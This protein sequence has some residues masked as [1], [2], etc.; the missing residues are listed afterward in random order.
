MPR[1]QPARVPRSGSNRSRDRHTLDEGL[2]GDVGREVAIAD[3]PRGV[4]EDQ[5]AACL[6]CQPESGGIPGGPGVAGLT[7][8]V[9]LG[10]HAGTVPAGLRGNRRVPEG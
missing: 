10:G 2:L 7:G 6:P 9:V 3:G 5:G 8:P 1:S 4:G